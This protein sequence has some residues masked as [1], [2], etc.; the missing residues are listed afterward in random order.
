MLTHWTLFL[1]LSTHHSQHFDVLL[2]PRGA[3]LRRRSEWSERRLQ[4][5]AH[6]AWQSQSE[7]MTL[8]ICLLGPRQCVEAVASHNFLDLV[9]ANFTDLKSVPADSGLVKPDTH[10]PPLS[11]D[12]YLPHF[13]NNL[14]REFSCRDFA[15]RNSA[16]LYNIQVCMKLLLL[17]YPSRGSMLLFEMPWGRQLLMAVIASPNSTP[18]FSNTLRYYIVNRSLKVAAQGPDFGPPLIHTYIHTHYIVK[19]NYFH[20]RF[21]KIWADYFHGKFV[22]YRKLTTN[23]IKSDRLR[24]LM[25]I[26]NNLK[27]QPHH[28][29]KYVSN[30]RK[31]RSGSV[32]LQADSAHLAQ[33]S[34]VA[35][36]FA[37]HFIS[38]Y[39]NHC[40][41]DIPPISQFSEFLSLDPI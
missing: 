34:A 32:Q 33:H 9:F 5:V 40:P 25:S 26:Y 39:N 14:N 28:F 21:K 13:I 30:F 36:T 10:H 11:T 29:W 12:V 27:S 7:W 20:R 23:S 2:R 3:Q 41:V 31:H 38:V 22:F 4:K 35:D 37:K 24:W 19:K 15:V 17:M 18:G 16:L 8:I 1:F 6:N